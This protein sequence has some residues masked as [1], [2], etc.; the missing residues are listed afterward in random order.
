MKV[1]VTG[2]SGFLGKQVVAALIASGHQ[3]IAISRSDTSALWKN[4]NV[5]SVSADLEQENQ[6]LHLEDC[7]AVVH[8]AASLSGSDIYEK[9]LKS[10]QN[11]LRAMEQQGLTWLILCSSL[12][13][14]DYVKTDANTVIEES[15]EPCKDD[16]LMGPY[17][18][19]KRDQEKAALS[20]ASESNNVTILRP[21]LIYSEE[22]L[23]EAHAGFL[24]KRF[25]L[26]SMHSGQVPLVHISSVASA[27]TNTLNLEVDNRNIAVHIVD[28]N[29]PDQSTYLRELK[30]NGS[31][32]LALPLPWKIYRFMMMGVYML[33]TI[34]GQSGRAPDTFKPNSVSGRCTPYKF[35]NARA[36][37]VLKWTPSNSANLVR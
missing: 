1:A 32:S 2:A 37:Q 28:N 13:V 36:R 35:D 5:Q 7:D 21:G 20:W 24:K 19:M 12:S 10:T 25:G 14:L 29:L 30:S 3:V 9:T 18:R 11:L 33:F 26:T 22:N 27:I 6:N 8:L 15:V 16:N 34:F 4:P 23:S 17:A 31:I